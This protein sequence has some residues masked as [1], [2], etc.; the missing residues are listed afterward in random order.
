MTLFD[1]FKTSRSALVFSSKAFRGEGFGEASG[2]QDVARA[3][4]S[5]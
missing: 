4:R 5:I 1:F 3:S 2:G